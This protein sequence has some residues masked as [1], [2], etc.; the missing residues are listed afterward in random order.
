VSILHFLTDD[1]D[2]RGIVA[3]IREAAAPGSYMVVSHV[4]GQ[5]NPRLAAAVRRLYTARAADGQARS[6]EEITRFF[7]DWELVEPGLVYAPRWRPVTPSEVPA[8]PDQFWFL[9]GVARKPEA[10]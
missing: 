6:R 9:S 5:D 10:G 2:P 7:G 3:R 8:H 1:D 4:T